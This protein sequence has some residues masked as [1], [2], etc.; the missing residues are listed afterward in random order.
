MKKQYKLYALVKNGVP[1]YVG[2]TVNVQLRI[3]Q[4][5]SSDKV[6]DSY[7]IVKS[8]DNKKD[9]LIAENSIIRYLSI[10]INDDNVNSKFSDLSYS[11][12]YKKTK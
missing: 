11:T 1:I 4:H 3:N 12:I 9:A 8:Y 10:F 7:V 2:C 5:K 6:F